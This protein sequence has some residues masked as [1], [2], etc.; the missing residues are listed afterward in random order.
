MAHLATAELASR[1]QHPATAIIEFDIDIW[2]SVWFQVQFRLSTII[3]ERKLMGGWN[4]VLFHYCGFLTNQRVSKTK[5]WSTKPWAADAAIQGQER[6]VHPSA[7]CTNILPSWSGPAMVSMVPSEGDFSGDKC[8]FALSHRTGSHNYRGTPHC[9][10]WY[11]SYLEWRHRFLWV[12]HHSKAY[13]FFCPTILEIE[14]CQGNGALLGW[15]Q[16]FC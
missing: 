1:T 2:P 16:R 4:L 5:V 8:M 13:C 11:Q 12:G 3:Q 9:H 6:E 14:D 15:Y 7:C 10:N